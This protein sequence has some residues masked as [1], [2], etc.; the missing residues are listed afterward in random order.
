MMAPSEQP[1]VDGENH[2][3]NVFTNPRRRRAISILREADSPLALADVAI[4]LARQESG[5]SDRKRDWNR[6]K[7][8]YIALYHNHIPRLQD[9]GLA[10]FD[11]DRK[12]V[13]L[14]ESPSV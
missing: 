7:S 8:I 3:H 13:T 6:I 2:Q 12:T 4:D 14:S 1:F 10:K 9:L 5:D 11:T